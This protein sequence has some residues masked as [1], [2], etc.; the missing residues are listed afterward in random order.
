MKGFN[1]SE[2]AYIYYRFKYPNRDYDKKQAN[3]QF[4]RDKNIDYKLLIL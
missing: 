1:K 3:H 2:I 4:S